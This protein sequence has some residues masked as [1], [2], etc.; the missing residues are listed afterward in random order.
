VFL[1]GG[2][3]MG[4]RTCPLV[5]FLGRGGLAESYMDSWPI[6]IRGR[7]ALGLAKLASAL[8]G[9]FPTSAPTL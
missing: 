5:P 1:G 6:G 9:P 7:A 3:Y 8:A 2:L 4:H